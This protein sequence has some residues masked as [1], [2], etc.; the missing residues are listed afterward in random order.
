MSLMSVQISEL[1]APSLAFRF[2][3][4]LCSLSSHAMIYV[5]YASM[6]CVLRSLQILGFR[7]MSLSYEKSVV[8]VLLVRY[9][10]QW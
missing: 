3:C 1:L 9:C 8:F 7:F 2:I 5:R 4:S 10:Y 6:Y